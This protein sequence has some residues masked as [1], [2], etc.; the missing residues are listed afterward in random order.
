M[1]KNDCSRIRI[2][3]CQRALK[4]PT[5]SR[6]EREFEENSVARNSNVVEIFIHITWELSRFSQKYSRSY[7]LKLCD[8]YTGLVC[9]QCLQ[10]GV[11]VYFRF[12]L[13]SLSFISTKVDPNNLIRKVSL[14]WTNGKIDLRKKSSLTTSCFQV[15]MLNAVTANFLG[16]NL[17]CW[18][19]IQSGKGPWSS[20]VSGIVKIGQ[21][22]TMVLGIK[23]QDAKF[24]MMVRNW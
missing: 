7:K 3:A 18:M 14:A 21:T 12:S 6:H 2:A 24:D 19:Q 4:L 15:N 20:E 22:M 8:N 16:D 13:I 17:Q 5:F 23:D 1:C 11:V 10:C 9:K